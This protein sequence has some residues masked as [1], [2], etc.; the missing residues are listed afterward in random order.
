MNETSCIRKNGTALHEAIGKSSFVKSLKKRENLHYC[1]D[2]LCQIAGKNLIN[3]LC[4]QDS[5]HFIALHLAVFFA[6]VD[7]VEK[8]INLAGE[9]A[10]ELTSIESCRGTSLVIAQEEYEHLASFDTLSK[11]DSAKLTRYQLIVKL[12]EKHTQ[13]IMVKNNHEF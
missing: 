6:R 12:L 7:I 11:S 4:V 2:V 1:I 10:S 8:L 13:I 9:K 5:H 3:F